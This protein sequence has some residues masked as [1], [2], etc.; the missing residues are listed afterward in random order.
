MV[1]IRPTGEREVLGFGVGDRENQHAWED[2]LEDL[3]DRGVKRIGLWVTDENQAML[4]TLTMK[5]ADSQRQRCVIHKIEN[6][7]SY[8]PTRQ[9]EQVEA[10]VKAIFYQ[11]NR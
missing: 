10:E 5:F 1:G 11:H 6:V 3:K 9:R 2:L 8:V 4:N 7:L